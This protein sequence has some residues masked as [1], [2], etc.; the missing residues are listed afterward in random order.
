MGLNEVFKKVY[1]INSSTELSKH[2]IELATIYDDLAGTMKQANAGF[3]QALDLRG[4]CANFCRE[5]LTKNQD[6]L[7][8]LNKVEPMLK[9]IGLDSELKKVQNAKSE[10]NKNISI[11]DKA[12]KNFLAI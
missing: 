2:E 8:E 9:S 6:I 3:I 10:V 5:S 7:K 4:K 12:Y 11:I 1:D